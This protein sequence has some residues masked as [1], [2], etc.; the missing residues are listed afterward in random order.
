MPNFKL[1]LPETST[2]EIT[3]EGKPVFIEDAIIL[4]TILGEAQKGYDLQKQRPIWEAKFRDLLNQRYNCS[5]TQGQTLVIIRATCE[6]TNSLKKSLHSLQISLAATESPL[7]I[8]P[9]KNNGACG[10]ISPGSKH[11]KNSKSAKPKAG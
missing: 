3:M 10:P 5:L 2:I 7:P 11:R 8:S 4:D 9:Q 6:L 1:D